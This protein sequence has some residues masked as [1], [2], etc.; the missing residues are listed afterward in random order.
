ML[1]RQTRTTVVLALFAALPALAS[2]QNPLPATPLPLRH[3]PQPTTPAITAA[4]LM[5]RLYIIADDS[6]M[7]REAGTL[8]NFKATDYIAAEA[9]KMGLVPAGDNGTYFQTVPMATRAVAPGATFTTADGATLTFG[10]DFVPAGV[11][12]VRNT[13]LGVVYG[14]MFGDTSARLTDAQVNGKLVVFTIPPGPAGLASLRRAGP[15][16]ANVASAAAVAIAVLDALPPR[17][18]AS[19]TRPR[20]VLVSKTPPPSRGPGTLLIT[21]AAAAKLFAAPIGS[22]APGAGGKT[23]S[24]SYSFA[25]TPV[26]YPARNV[27]GIVPGSDPVVKGEYVAVGAHN[28]HVGISST[29]ADHDSLRIFNQIVRPGGAEDSNNQATAEQQARVNAQLAEWRRTH[30]NTAR[31]DSINNGADDDGSGSASVLEIA[32]YFASM[33]TKPRRSMLFVWHVGEEKGLFGSQ[34]YTD[35]TTV[36]RDSIVAQLN[37]DMVGRGAATDVTGVT[38]DGKP[39]PGGNDYL[40]LVGSRRLSRELGDLVEQVNTSRKY[41]LKL[42]YS[43]DANGHPANIYCRSDHYSYARY[44]IPIVFFTT[45]VHSDYHQLADEPQYIQYDHMARVDNFIADVALNTANLNHRVV[46]D[47]PKPDPNGA[48][49]Q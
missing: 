10:A 43:M 18:V 24:L 40:S 1:S 44:G 15:G 26:P 4:D 20:T 39:I 23:V 12:T 46:V 42:D 34:Y 32:Q 36:P 16:A 47:Q 6:M 14:G 28:D 33:P 27:V 19:L 21:S 49:R 41:N 37:I 17:A 35:N 25:D 11:G 31:L 8:G 30:P 48:C 3:T 9:R 2:A 5:T 22:L 29:P 13:A 38:A 45:G 7:G